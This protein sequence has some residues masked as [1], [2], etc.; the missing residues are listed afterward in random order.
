MP[1]S[2]L[3]GVYGL[4]ASEFWCQVGTQG[5]GSWAEASSGCFRSEVLGFKVWG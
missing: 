5:C 3:S 4:G 2:G 1:G